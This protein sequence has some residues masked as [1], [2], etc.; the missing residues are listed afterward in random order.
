[1]KLALENLLLPNNSGKKDKGLGKCGTSKSTEVLEAFEAKREQ[2]GAV[3]QA[4]RAE[5]VAAVLA[6][7]K[8]ALA[9]SGE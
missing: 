3:F 9:A 2:L 8:T 6:A 1:M 7:V 5:D 4:E